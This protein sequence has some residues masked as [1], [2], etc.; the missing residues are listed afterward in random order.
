MRDEELR[1]LERRAASGAPSDVLAHVRALDRLGLAD[2][3]YQALVP[4]V[5]DGTL[6][7]ELARRPA[8]TQP[9]ADAGATRYLDVEPIR[10]QPRVLWTRTLPKPV[11]RPRRP[12]PSTRGSLVASPLGVVVP[13]AASPEGA[14]LD[15][16]TGETRFT[17]PREPTDWSNLRVR[18]G[19]LLTTA[20]GRDAQGQPTNETKSVAAYDLFTG[21]WLW[22]RPWPTTW[23]AL[24][25][26]GDLLAIGSRLAR[27]A[28]PDPREAPEPIPL[29]ARVADAYQ[30]ASS[31]AAILGTGL[32]DP[33]G[34][35]PRGVEWYRSADGGPVA[36]LVVRGPRIDAA[37]AVVWDSGVAERPGEVALVTGPRLVA[38]DS[39]GRELWAAS[40]VTGAPLALAPGHVLGPREG[41]VAVVERARGEVTAT[42]DSPVLARN[43]ELRRAWERPCAAVS[44]DVVYLA[45]GAYLWAQPLAGGPPL[46]TL[47]LTES[48]GEIRALA[49][50]PRRIFVW[51]A[52]PCVLCVAG[53]P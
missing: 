43:R 36:R 6:R 34:G 2:D 48:V 52:N 11:P 27:H 15:P 53:E 42:L 32:D 23:L 47:D 50:L 22:R 21:V 30:V 46:W 29:W 19:V 45:L 41:R 17:I 31:E 38:H 12:V 16:A 13:L 44:R 3:A 14:V 4:H 51:T 37:G 24:H 20:P 9:D 39:G 35:E 7:A 40:G 1:D 25:A 8:W 10:R 26:S 5:A 28:W 18:E 49:V 33:F